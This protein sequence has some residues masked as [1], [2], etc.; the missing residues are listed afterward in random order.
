MKNKNII[1]NAMS[2]FGGQLIVIILGIII[3]RIMISKYGSDINGL[4][5]TT[6]QIFSY[7]ALLEAGIGQSARIAL[8]KPISEND[9]DSISEVFVSAEAYFHRITVYYAVGVIVLSIISPFIIK[10]NVSYIT[11]FLVMVFEGFSSVFSFYF[12]QTPSIL[13]S[14]D[15]KGYINNYINLANK[16]VGYIVKILLASAGMNIVLLQATFFLI[17]ICKVIFYRIYLKKKYNWVNHDK[18]VNFSLLKDKNSYLVTEIAWT[19]FSSTDMIVLSIFVSTK[20]SS[21][22]SIYNLIYAN[23]NLLMN[24]VGGSILYIL[25]QIYHR[26]ISEYESVHDAMNGFFIGGMTIMLSVSYMLTIPFIKLYTRGVVDVEYIY[27]QLPLMYA[28]IQ[29]LSW[30]RYVNGNLTALSGF[31]KS[32]SYISLLEAITNVLLSVILVQKYGISGVLFATVIALPIKVIWC[33]YISDKKVLRRSY[34]NTIKVFFPNYIFFFIIAFINKYISLN[35]TSY[36]ELA[37]MGIVSILIIGT[38]NVIM[39]ICI[40]NKILTIIKKYMLKHNEN[41]G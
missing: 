32:T 35:V 7:L 31:A 8:Y 28:I 9:R 29:M 23:I 3:P 19:I 41:G 10:S 34:S 33:I 25:G 39:N 22:Y 12:I 26:N 11:I 18:I 6:T 38:L 13:L 27:P 16:I 5:A 40:N 30:S 4:V 24:A 21:V 15:G 37:I 2:G 20:L 14:A 36:I 17:T 1:K